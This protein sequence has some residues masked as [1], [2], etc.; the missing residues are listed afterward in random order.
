MRWRRPKTLCA[1]AGTLWNLLGLMLLLLLLLLLVLTKRTSGSYSGIADTC[2]AEFILPHSNTH[3]SYI[4]SGSIGSGVA[5]NGFM[6]KSLSIH[7][8]QGAPLSPG[9]RT[10]PPSASGSVPTMQTQIRGAP[11]AGRS[12]RSSQLTRPFSSG[13][14]RSRQRHTIAC[15]AAEPQA[16]KQERTAGRMTYRPESYAELVKD[17]T[18]SVLAAIEDGV[19]LMEVEFPAV[20]ANIEGE[21]RRRPWGCMRPPSTALQHRF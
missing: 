9:Q 17:A 12:L 20:P 4:S 16:A 3:L 6:S 8:T 13:A 21:Q 19:T 18:K 1:G 14:A 11:V 15:S 10:L 7:T 2:M 5:R